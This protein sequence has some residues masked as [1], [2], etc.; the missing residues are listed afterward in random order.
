MTPSQVSQIYDLEVPTKNEKDR[1]YSSSTMNFIALGDTPSVVRF[2]FFQNQL[3]AVNWVLKP[4]DSFDA[5]KSK[6]EHLFTEIRQ[7]HPDLG[8]IKQNRTPE[9]TD[10]ERPRL[11]KSHVE[12]AD[13]LT[14]VYLAEWR[15]RD[16]MNVSMSMSESVRGGSVKIE[17]QTTNENALRQLQAEIAKLEREKQAEFDKNEYFMKLESVRKEKEEDER[18]HS[19]FFD[20]F[21]GKNIK[22]LTENI[23]APTSTTA[24]P[25]GEIIYVWE[26]LVDNELHCRTSVFANRNSVIYSWQWSGN[27]CRRKLPVTNTHPKKPEY[28][29]L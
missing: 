21:V 17:I 5:N 7:E 18:R 14:R 27:A 2:N 19:K 25:K 22:T 6:Y 12:W 26:T 11:L 24:M 13:K 1:Q 15:A 3:Y 28:L 9:I 4:E 29:K 20:S 8:F 23:G 10:A 16:G